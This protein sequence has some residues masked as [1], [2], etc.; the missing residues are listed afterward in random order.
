MGTHAWLSKNRRHKLNVGTAERLAAVT[1]LQITRSYLKNRIR[2]RLW[3]VDFYP[4]QEDLSAR[5]RRVNLR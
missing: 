4:P 1:L 3:R 2:A 5:Q